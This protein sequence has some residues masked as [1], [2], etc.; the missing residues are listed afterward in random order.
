MSQ[1]P[2]DHIIPYKDS[3]KSKKEQVS[4]MFDRIAGKYD[5]MNRFLSAR[6]DIHWRKKA[7]KGLKKDDFVCDCSDIDDMIIVYKDGRYVISKVQEKAFVGKNIIHITIFKKNDKR[8]I[9]NVVYR[10]GKRGNT[11]MKRFAVTGITRDKEYDVTK[12]TAGSSVMYFSANPN[13]ES[14]ILKVVLRP[15]ARIRNLVFDVD[16]GELAIKGRAAQGGPA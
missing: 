12:G 16:M 10:D 15:K 8:T 11:Y 7:I 6:T 4:E 13:G 14:E 9:Y 5:A 3:L 2:H 1:L